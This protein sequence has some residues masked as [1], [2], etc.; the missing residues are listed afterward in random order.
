MSDLEE[1]GRVA[2]AQGIFGGERAVLGQ[3]E[4]KGDRLWVDFRRSLS[5]GPVSQSGATGR[6]KP[7]VAKYPLPASVRNSNDMTP[8]S[9]T[10]LWFAPLPAAKA[11][12]RSADG[13]RPR[14]PT[15]VAEQTVFSGRIH[16]PRRFNKWD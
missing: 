10:L 15:M 14:K 3:R 4:R 9:P 11:D 16:M 13:H 5:T 12:G 1:P 6:K 7:I 2:V 8:F